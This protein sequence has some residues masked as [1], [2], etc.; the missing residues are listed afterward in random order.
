MDYREGFWSVPG[1]WDDGIVVINLCCI[2]GRNIIVGFLDEDIPKIVESKLRSD[3]CRQVQMSQTFVGGGGIILE[4]RV[5]P[6]QN[7][8]SRTC[9]ITGSEAGHK[10]QKALFVLH[11]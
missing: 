11:R 10:V 3:R 7:F 6:K 2:V 8:K 1:V 4:H 5:V 9:D